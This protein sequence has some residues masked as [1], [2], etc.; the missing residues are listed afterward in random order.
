MAAQVHLTFI[1]LYFAEII[2]LLVETDC[3]YHNYITRLDD[4]NG[5]STEPDVTDAEVFVFLALTI[6]MEHGIRDKLTDFWSTVDQLFTHFY[7][8]VMKWDR[9]LHILHYLPFTNNRN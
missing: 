2:T 6:Q 7:G 4:D 1:L 8:S 5:P 3:Y 9:Y